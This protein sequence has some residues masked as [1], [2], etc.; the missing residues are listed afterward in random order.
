MRL[1]KTLQ[2][3][4]EETQGLQDNIKDALNPLLRLPIV[5][6]VL[7]EGIALVSGSDN[8]V[9]HT[10]GRTPRMWIRADIQQNANVWRSAWNSTILTLQ[11]DVNCTISLWVA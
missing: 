9:S 8:N 4:A 7:L 1:F 5:D 2:F 3:K 11:T 10:L 6:G